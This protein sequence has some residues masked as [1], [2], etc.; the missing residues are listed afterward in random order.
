MNNIKYFKK[1]DFCY[2]RADR[3][4]NVFFDKGEERY[5]P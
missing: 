3:Y 2:F 5:S 4:N 1:T